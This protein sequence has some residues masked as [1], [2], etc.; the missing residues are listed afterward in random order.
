MKKILGIGGG[1]LAAGG[2]AG[3]WG[4]CHTICTAAIVALGAVGITVTGMPL[5]FLNNPYVY[6]PLFVVGIGLMGVSIYFWK[7]SKTCCGAK[8]TCCTGQQKIYNK[9]ANKGLKGTNGRK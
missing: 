7:R 5:M 1:V 3:A 2:G 6:V 8:E 4:V 9:R